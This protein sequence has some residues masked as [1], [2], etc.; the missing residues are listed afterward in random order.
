LHERLDSA[1]SEMAYSRRHSNARGLI[2]PL[3]DMI[4]G[5]AGLTIVARQIGGAVVRS[6]D[7]GW[8]V[9]EHQVDDRA[10]ARTLHRLGALVHDRR[11]GR[12]PA[13]GHV[14]AAVAGQRL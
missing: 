13:M 10:V 6:L 4:V 2:A 8:Q 12:P 3:L 7:A 11:E 14:P 1:I 9:S 5:D